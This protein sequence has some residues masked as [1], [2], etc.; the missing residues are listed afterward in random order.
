MD[1][2]RAESSFHLVPEQR[3]YLVA[4][5]PVEDATGLLGIV[6]MVVELG[7]MFDR[8]LDR[9]RGYFVKQDPMDLGS[10]YLPEP[11]G[12]VPGYRLAPRSGSVAR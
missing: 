4:D 1:P 8:F 3:A 10:V 5:Q 11:L 9:I 6:E 7:R 12:E 2:P